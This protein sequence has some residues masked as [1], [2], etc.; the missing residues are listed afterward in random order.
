[1]CVC[2][3]ERLGFAYKAEGVWSKNQADF[4]IVGRMYEGYLKTDM[5]HIVLK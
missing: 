5:E 3:S 2:V 1:M 4:H